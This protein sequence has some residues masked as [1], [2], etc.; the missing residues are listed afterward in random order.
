MT[1]Q[2]KTVALLA[3][4]SGLLIAISY[5]ILGGTTGLIVGIGLAAASNLFS[6]YQSD[7]IA[8]AVYR[9]QPVS[10]SEAP[11]LHRM[12]QRLSQ[13]ANIPMPGVYIVPGPTANAF[14]TGRDPEHA[15]VAVTEGILNI[16]PEDELEGVLAHELTHII[17]RDT[18]TQAVAAT[19]AGTI[20]FL[21]QMVSYSLWFGGVGSRDDNRGA[22]PLGIL[23]TVILAPLAATI[24]QLAISRTREFS[25]DAGA[26]RLTG[27]PRA[28][29][30]ALQRL[31]LTARQLPLNA[32]PAFEPL[33]II[34]PISGQ[35]LGNLFSSHPP[36]EAR[37]EQLLK[38]E[39]KLPTTAY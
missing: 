9:A 17:N 7:K 3:A 2:L 15:A 31:E 10:A 30:R 22:N 21:A 27:N 14:A 37:V 20:S 39:Q 13:W 8:L 16:L 6:W 12:V 36:T 23:L 1:N 4:L 32:N 19:I 33:L 26:A 24:I 28:L 35:F 18:L 38:L 29:A 25:A 11:G 34:N 5:W